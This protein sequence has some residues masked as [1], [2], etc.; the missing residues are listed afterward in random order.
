MLQSLP[1]SC[2]ILIAQ[3]ESWKIL[4]ASLFPPYSL[5]TYLSIQLNLYLYIHMYT[6]ISVSQLF[7]ILDDG[8]SP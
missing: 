8:Q 6:Y 4:G 7:R 2:C 3:P 1:T 5:L